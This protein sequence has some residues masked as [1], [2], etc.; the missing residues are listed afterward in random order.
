[1]VPVIALGTANSFR[2]CPENSFRSGEK[3]ERRNACR[4]HDTS[5]RVYRNC[6]TTVPARPFPLVG[7][8]FTVEKRVLPLSNTIPLVIRSTPTFFFPNRSAVFVFT[9]CQQRPTET[10]LRTNS[11]LSIEY[12]CAL[13]SLIYWAHFPIAYVFSVGLYSFFFFRN[14][15]IFLRENPL[16]ISPLPI[17]RASGHSPL[18]SAQLDLAKH[19]RQSTNGQVQKQE[20]TE[21]K[22]R[23]PKN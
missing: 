14:T 9:C 8:G 7:F 21:T 20:R 11:T 3:D 4:R 16:G 23:F 22:I 5:T 1:M 12:I 19:V 18:A 6:Q 2:T 10:V 15:Y 13:N 17:L